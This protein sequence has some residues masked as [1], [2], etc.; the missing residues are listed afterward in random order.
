[1]AFIPKNVI[2]KAEDI[3]EL[4][5]NYY[6]NLEYFFLYYLFTFCFNR[7]LKTVIHTCLQLLVYV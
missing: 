4:V 3:S 1:M 5:I 7:L 2:D 6:H